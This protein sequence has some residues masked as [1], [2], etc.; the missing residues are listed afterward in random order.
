MRRTG[1]RFAS[2]A[3]GTLVRAGTLNANSS[4]ELPAA[5]TI[6]AHFPEKIKFLLNDSIGVAE[7]HRLGAGFHLERMPARHHENVMRQPG[8]GSIRYLHPSLAFDHDEHAT[9]RAPVGFRLDP[10]RH[11]LH[12]RG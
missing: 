12:R 1:N 2:P 9:R 11:E 3:I 8:E 5:S 10:L 4:P 7:N 6:A